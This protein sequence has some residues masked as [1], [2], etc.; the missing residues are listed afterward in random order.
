[1]TGGLLQVVSYGANDLFLTG[2]PEITFF[3]IVYRRH[4]NFASESI[5]VNFNGQTGFGQI[6]TLTIPKIGDL[7]SKIYLKIIL[8][9]I[10]IIRNLPN[11]QYTTEYDN[12]QQNFNILTQFMKINIAAYRNAIYVLNALNS[13]PNEV[14]VA[15]DASFDLIQNTTLKTDFINILNNTHF[16][17]SYISF[18][19]IITQFKDEHN[20][21]LPGILKTNIK[22][23]LNLGLRQCQLVYNYFYQELSKYRD[24]VKDSQNNYAKTAWVSKL[25][26][27]IIKSISI[28]IGGIEIDRQYGD[29]LNIW[30]E[31]CGNKHYQLIHDKMIGNVRELTNP[32]RQIKPD[33]V[34]YVPLQ[35]WFCK[36][37]GLALPINAL[38]YHQV[39]MQLEF[40]KF[41]ECFYYSELTVAE[42]SNPVLRQ[43]RITELNL[44]DLDD[45]LANSNLNLYASLLID[46]I[47]LDHNERKLFAQSK[48]EYLITQIQL[49]ELNNTNMPEYNLI[50]NFKHQC[51]QLIWIIQNQK[52]VLVTDNHDKLEWNN[53]TD[54]I[55]P[56]D[57][58]SIEFNRKTRVP[59]LNYIYYN[60]VQPYQHYNSTPDLGINTYSFAFKPIEHQPSGMANLGK[61]PEVMLKLILNQNLLQ[62]NQYNIRVY[63]V[64]Y[65][66]LR[67]ISGMAGLAFTSG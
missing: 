62:N 23:S 15:I 28:F 7:I 24:L 32:S 12:S 57:K 10:S 1:M 48:H 50:L 11:N 39:E 26:Y 44:P 8:P 35:F 3:K 29:W 30:N 38:Q 47:Y 37:N 36:N 31:L 59:L 19:D 17:F 49:F 34:L 63:A 21:I 6:Q 60:S 51:K 27:S 9:K 46:Y 25:G 53:Y 13:T 55:Y 16:V 67:F 43:T 5:E 20:D 18:Q 33:Y 52:Y 58:C 42:L 14:L 40:R 45:F 61:I 54:N 2:T 64:N 65:N 22:K 56:I 66:I 41:S 4:T